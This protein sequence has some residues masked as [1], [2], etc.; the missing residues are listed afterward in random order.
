LKQQIRPFRQRL[1]SDEQLSAGLMAVVDEVQI[2]DEP[3]AMTSLRA[4]ELSRRAQISFQESRDDLGLGLF[5]VLEFVGGYMVTLKDFTNAPT[6]GVVI[7]TD[8]GG[9]RSRDRLVDI[10][11]GLNIAA[12]E[13]TWVVPEIQV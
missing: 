7:N 13:L 1:L 10:L 8:P 11:H 12:E 9:S 5:A 3:V 2:P 6:K 4:S